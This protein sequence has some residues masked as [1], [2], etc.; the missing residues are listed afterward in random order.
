MALATKNW[1]PVCVYTKAGPFTIIEGNHRL[2]AYAGS[3][4]A[5]LNISALAGLSQNNFY[6]RLSDLPRL[7]LHDL[8]K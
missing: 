2:V 7:V 6:F 3:P 5:G 8:W 4:K 1:S